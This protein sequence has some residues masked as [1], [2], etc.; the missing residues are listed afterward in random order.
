MTSIIK[1]KLED[2][3]KLFLSWRFDSVEFL[4]LPS[5]KENRPL[6]LEEIY[7]PLSFTWKPGND[8][9]F[10]L[11]EALEASRQLVVLGDPGCGKSTLVKLI[12]YSFGRAASTPL[13]RR[14]GPL[15]PIPIILRDY[16]V[17]LWRSKKDMLRDFIGKLDEDIRNRITVERLLAALREGR[18]FLLLD[19]L[20]EVGTREDRLHLREIVRPL[21][22]EIGESFAVLTSRIVGYDEAPFADFPHRIKFD[23]EQTTVIVWPLIASRCYVA[24]FNDEDIEKFITRWYAARERD[25]DRRREGINSLGRALKQNDRI[26]RLAGNPSLLTLMTLIHRVTAHLP[27][28]RVKLYDK[29]V[30]AYLETIQTYRKLDQYPASLDQMKRWLARVGW[31]MQGL[32]NSREQ[33]E[34]LVSRTDV[35]KWLTEAIGLDRV[36]AEEEARQFLDYVARRSGLLIPRGPEEFS[37]VH[38]TFQEYFA[39]F[40]LRGLLG[41]FEHLAQTCNGLVENQLWHETLTLL[42]EMLAE[43]PGAGDDLLDEIVNGTQEKREKCEGAAELFSSLLLDDQSGLGMAKQEE[44]AAFALRASSQQFDEAILGRLRQLSPDRFHQYV[45]KW[46]E[47]ELWRAEPDSVGRDFFVVGSDL[48][49]DWSKSLGNWVKKRGDLPWNEL[50]IEDVV[51]AGLE[52]SEVSAW[53]AEILPLG[54]WLRPRLGRWSNAVICFA[55][56]GLSALL[57]APARSPRHRLLTQSSLASSFT[58]SLAIRELSMALALRQTRDRSLER[59]LNRSLDKP[60]RWARDLALDIALYQDSGALARAQAR[61]LARVPDSGFAIDLV[62]QLQPTHALAQATLLPRPRLSKAN[63]EI[64]S[65]AEAEWLFFSPG[66]PA[67]EFNAARDRLHAMAAV[68]DDWTRVLA[69]SALLMLGEG[70]PQLCLTRNELLEKGI[71]HS[72]AFTFSERLRPETDTPRFREE[73]PEV[74]RLTFLHD[75]DDPWL[76]PEKFDPSNPDSRFFLSTPREFYAL[77]A[78]VLDPEGKTDLAKWHKKT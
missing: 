42:F 4:G 18:G 48:L 8:E 77:A 66:V 55:E 31:E 56:A 68:E 35:F 40:H 43:F 30:E 23:P 72:D 49:P 62:R 70:S 58:G 61:A 64:A 20:D 74:L 21:L 50:Q 75:P 6:T 29:I 32:R 60:W 10:Y 41:R 36:G 3:Y 28:G 38:L 39:A 16:Q 53:A 5:L 12:T 34:L 25:P 71:K 7:I 22:G 54:A 17:R 57:R 14:F 33:S 65:L 19:G 9:R 37:F 63:T 52:S 1:E 27:S 51:L 44:A 46:M 59:A 47:R 45:R 67:D 15:V 76:T 13:S 11:P 69:L 24:P 78:E 73:L 26:R 2:D